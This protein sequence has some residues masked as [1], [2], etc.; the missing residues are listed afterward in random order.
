MSKGAQQ[1]GTTTQ[2][3][4]TA[5]YMYPYMGTALGQAGNLLQQGGPGVYSGQR[6]ADFNPI[7]SQAFGGI[8]SAA[9]DV[10]GLNRATT[11]DSNIMRGNGNPYEN[12]M[13]KQAANSTQNQ[14]ASEFAGSGRDITG[15]MPLRAQQL[16]QLGTDFYGQNYQNTVQNAL[17]AG[18]QAQGIYDTRLQGQQQALQAGNQIQQ[19]GQ[20]Q[21]NASMDAY[22]QSQQRP[23]QNLSQFEQY[24]Q[25]VQPGA[26]TQTPYFQNKGANTLGTALAGQQLYNGYQ[27]KGTGG[28]G[29]GSV[30][31]SSG[32]ALG[33]AAN[34]S[35]KG[36]Q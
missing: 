25:G 22:N 33:S 10:N 16:N 15:S 29:G 3:Q 32:S 12:A 11:M 18:N 31:G 6:V 20:N 9:N 8:Q 28:S 2:S 5:P 4:T 21:I 17:Q 1:A 24:L 7:Q 27:G 30:A 19:Q 13:F 34:S 36:G 23:Y 26:Q 14:L 35:S